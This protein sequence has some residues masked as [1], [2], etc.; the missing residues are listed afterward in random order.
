MRNSHLLACFALPLAVAA[1]G[2]SDDFCDCNTGPAGTNGIS[3]LLAVH[4]EPPGAQCT[5]GGTRIDAGP[6]ADGDGSLSPSE[7]EHTQYVCRG[8]DGS[9]GPNGTPGTSGS[10]G[11]HTLVRMT[12]EPP[13]ANCAFG[14][15]AISAGHD[16][17][18]NGILDDIEVAETGHVC[19]GR[20]GV[21]GVD[22]ISGANGSN[23]ANGADAPDTL[24]RLVPSAFDECFPAPSH[25]LFW[26]TDD[27]RNGILEDLE[28]TMWGT[29]TCP[30]QRDIHL[31][32]TTVSEPFWQA[33]PNNGYVAADD[34][35][36][37]V[38]N[39]PPNGELRVG[40]IIRVS[41][42]GQGGWRIGQNPG[43]SVRV[44][45][46]GAPAA[47]VEWTTTQPSDRSGIVLWTSHDG[48][49]LIGYTPNEF[50]IPFLNKSTDRGATW[51]PVTA[52]PGDFVHHFAGSAD[53]R[54][55]L[56]SYSGEGGYG[57]QLRLSRDGG[58]TWALVGPEGQ[59]TERPWLSV[60][61]SA[62]GTRMLA[63]ATAKSYSN[64]PDYVYVSTDFGQTWTARESM[65]NA[66]GAAC[67]ADCMRV[68]VFADNQ[69][70]RSIDGGDS[71]E[72]T[73]PEGSWS[74]IAVSADGSK[75][76]ATQW[77]G[78]IH[79]SDDGGQTW[80]AVGLVGHFRRIVVSADGRKLAAEAGGGRIHI[81]EDGGQTWQPYGPSQDW[82][83]LVASADLSKLYG[84][85]RSGGTFLSASTE[86]TKLG[87]QGW[88]S[89][90]PFE[91]ITLQYAGNGNF[92]V[93][94]SEGALL[95]SGD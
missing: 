73:G 58:A 94:A 6:D 32:W 31:R 33:E 68:F 67:S 15:K 89:G 12:D 49:T 71:W 9:A 18:R 37:V 10:D 60:A 63:T 1:C 3:V 74:T 65:Q 48:D 76:A 79:I 85:R 42:I 7:V 20:Q 56:A 24:W 78:Q 80:T 44:R 81:S 72:P 26:G 34:A 52:F 13:G 64:I 21:D 55:L 47:G 35:Q 82:T 16:T 19:H 39:L 14:G 54:Y 17:N 90:G 23:G 4:A 8:A 5:G 62:D 70:Y 27:N 38:I 83:G 93:L 75:V 53:G 91:S 28:T 88:I 45:N 95:W 77:P 92:E 69:I 46:I 50:D 11:L 51:A 40:D 29:V 22:G 41:G 2:G 86:W 59:Y 87:T 36:Q 61:M 25:V 43:Q 84:T 30:G 66:T 57:T